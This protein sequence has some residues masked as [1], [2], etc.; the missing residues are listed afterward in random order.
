MQFP[1]Y[2]LIF[3]TQTFDNMKKLIYSTLALASLIFA[4]ACD[5]MNTEPEPK[6]Y[7]NTWVVNFNKTDDTA[8]DEWMVFR[9]NADGTAT[10]GGVL[11]DVETD[12]KN[13]VDMEKLTPEQKAFVD[14][15]K[16]NDVWAMDGWYSIKI[17]SDGSHVLCIVYDSLYENNEIR[18]EGQSFSFKDVSKDHM[19]LFEGLDKND[20]PTFYDVFS[21]ET[22]TLKIGTFY[23]EKYFFDIPKKDADKS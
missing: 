11:T 14:G 12:F 5:K 4:S 16:D 7:V 21:A 2:I 20:K 17:N 10:I 13:E 23:N 15:L 19:L 9:L 3:K 18:R 1:L 22:S 6:L 8:K